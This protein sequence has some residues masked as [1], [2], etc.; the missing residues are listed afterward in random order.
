[1]PQC[2]HDKGA[3]TMLDITENTFEALD[4]R[5][6]LQQSPEFHDEDAEREFRASHDSADFVDWRRPGK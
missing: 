2:N 1:M 5:T 4:S 6:T 3:M